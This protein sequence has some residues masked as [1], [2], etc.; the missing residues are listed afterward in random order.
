MDFIIPTSSKHKTI[1]LLL[2][3]LHFGESYIGEKADI[4]TFNI[5]KTQQVTL[6]HSRWMNSTT[7]LLSLWRICLR[8]KN[9]SL[10]T[11]LTFGSWLSSEP[12]G[13]TSSL[14]VCP[15]LPSRAKRRKVSPSKQS[16]A[17]GSS[18]LLANG[19]GW[20]HQ[21]STMAFQLPFGRGRTRLNTLKKKKK[22][23]S[24]YRFSRYHCPEMFRNDVSCYLSIS[25]VS[26]EPEKIKVRFIERRI[27]IWW[28]F[29]FLP[30]PKVLIFWVLFLGHLV[31]QA[32]NA[33]LA[34]YYLN[35][36]LQREFNSSISFY[37]VL[38]WCPPT[39]FCTDKIQYIDDDGWI[40]DSWELWDGTKTVTFWALK[41]KQWAERC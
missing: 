38:L 5:S 40:Q 25:T 16:S 7:A 1:F 4:S 8:S 30:Q 14:R 19:S 34:Y 10:W 39:W 15:Q 22:K 35:I 27:R 28:D 11:S 12:T 24:N 32:V 18:F 13:L 29:F 31:E 9:E 21:S 41:P 17:R 36:N 33:I 20:Q 6:K 2:W 3:E 26:L 23:K 37:L